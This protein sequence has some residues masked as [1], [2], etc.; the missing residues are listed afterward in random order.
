MATPIVTGALLQELERLSTRL[1]EIIE[2]DFEP[3][4]RDQLNWR[5]APQKWSILECLL[6]LNYFAGHYFPPIQKALQAGR[7]TRPAT[8]FT[9]S[10]LGEHYLQKYRLPIDNQLKRRLEAPPQYAPPESAPQHSDLSPKEV[11]HTFEQHQK[12]LLE[13]LRQAHLINLQRI[14][15]PAFWWGLV[16]LRLGDLL[17]ILVYH[18]ERHIVQAQRV[19]YHDHFPGNVPLDLLLTEM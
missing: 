12:Q 8:H 10:W 13:F 4:S 9:S 17:Q 14:S 2:R 5:P 15:V 3:L 16:K 18:N 7:N 1:S 6:H 11:L 19:L